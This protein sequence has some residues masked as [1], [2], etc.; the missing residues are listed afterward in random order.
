MKKIYLITISLLILG[1]YLQA[2]ELGIAEA[3]M[4]EVAFTTAA[5]QNPI[6][7]TYGCSSC[8][9]VGGFDPTNHIAFVAHLS[10]PQQTQQD[11]IFS[12]IKSLSSEPF[13]VS[14][15]FH[16]RG[17]LRN[18][19]TVAAI[20]KWISYA[21]TNYFATKIVSEEISNWSKMSSGSLKI[22]ARTGEVGNYNPEENPNRRACQQDIGDCF[23]ALLEARSGQIRVAYCPTT[24]SSVT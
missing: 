3:L 12:K 6:V 21:K 11:D 22:D 18:I 8:V 19:G 2:M 1:G 10:V 5:D 9:A 4:G 15:Q 20:R 17:G 7:A 23:L 14:V 24:I 13:K 16:L